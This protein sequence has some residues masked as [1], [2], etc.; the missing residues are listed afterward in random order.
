[1][2]K[3]LFITV[4]ELK[5][6]SVI[7]GNVD[8]DKLIQFIEVA[9]ET[10]IQNYMG[11]NLYRRV[12]GILEAGTIDDGPNA[13]YKTLWVDYVKP[14]L[15]WFSQDSFLPF[16]MFQ[17]T[18]GGVF[19]HTHEASETIT[20]DELRIMQQQVRQN[21]EFYA[22][23]F[24]DYVCDNETLFPEYRTRENDSDIWPDQDPTYLG[25]VL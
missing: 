3:A 10:H 19:K 23:R 5:K 6:K 21:A 17:I 15:F 24:V 20:V 4:D 9:Q 1:M 22:R 12:K 11:T 7:D 16:A 14:M 2:S 25:W 13:A 18:N 8:D